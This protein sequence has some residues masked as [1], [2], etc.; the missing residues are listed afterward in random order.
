MSARLFSCQLL[1]GCRRKQGFSLDLRLS[2]LDLQLTALQHLGKGNLRFGGVGN[3]HGIK[4]SVVPWFFGGV[5]F[6]VQGWIFSPEKTMMH[7]GVSMCLK[8]KDSFIE[9]NCFFLIAWI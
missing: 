7:S 5:L 9:S 8:T 1:N 6:F 3:P 4:G 2:S